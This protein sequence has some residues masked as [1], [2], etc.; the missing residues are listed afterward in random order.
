MK[1]RSFLVAAFLAAG[2][3][4]NKISDQV[5]EFNDRS[6]KVSQPAEFEFIVSDTNTLY[7]IS[8]TLRNS[9]DYPYA[10]LFVNYTLTDSIGQKISEKMISEYLFDQKTG[11]PQGQSGLGDLYDHRFPLLRGYKFNHSGKFKLKMEQVMRQD[12]L[13]GVLAVGLLIEKSEPEQQ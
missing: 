5:L 6:W 12:T 10:R 2:C 13:K 3:D 4:S 8:C 7:N 11:E 1:W 9:L